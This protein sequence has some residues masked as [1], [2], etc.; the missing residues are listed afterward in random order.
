M[1]RFEMTRDDPPRLDVTTEQLLLTWKEGGHN[2]GCLKFGPDGYLY[3]STGDAGPASP[4]DPE[5]VGQDLTNLLSSI[6]RHRRR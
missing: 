6:L 1:S 3:V 4:P 2:G 5:R